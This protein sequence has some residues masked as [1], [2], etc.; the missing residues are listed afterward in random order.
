M[1]AFYFLNI[2]S[3]FLQLQREK[4]TLSSLEGVLD[5]L[6]EFGVEV[7]NADIEHLSVLCPQVIRYAI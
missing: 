6:A 1:K 7:G 5:Q 4:V 2:Y 3:G